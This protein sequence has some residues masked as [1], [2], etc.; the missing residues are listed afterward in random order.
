LAQTSLWLNGVKRAELSTLAQDIQ[1][2]LTSLCWQGLS[3]KASL[4]LRLLAS[5]AGV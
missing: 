3:P 2:H 4:T 5:L 1:A